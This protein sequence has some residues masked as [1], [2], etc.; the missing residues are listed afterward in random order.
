MKYKEILEEKISSLNNNIAN[1][2]IKI[3]SIKLKE[4]MNT[5]DSIKKEIIEKL[6][7]I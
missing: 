1:A 4:D 3:D 7:N 5:E 2:I 6:F